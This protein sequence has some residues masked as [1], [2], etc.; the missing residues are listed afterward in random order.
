MRDG[1]VAI[2]IPA[3]SAGLRP[4][5]SVEYLLVSQDSRRTEIF[6]RRASWRR[7]VAEA[8]GRFVLHDVEIG[9]DAIYDE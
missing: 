3:T 2:H 4:D 9:V 7:E 1:S 6:R 5:A 8:G